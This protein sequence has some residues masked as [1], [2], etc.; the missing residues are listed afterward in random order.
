H[1]KYRLASISKTFASAL[2]GHLVDQGQLSYDTPVNQILRPQDFPVKRWRSP[3]EKS[4]H[5]VNITVRQLL[6]HTAGLHITKTSDFDNVTVTHNTTSMI[7]KFKDEPLHF[8]P[9]TR[10]KYSN[11]GFQVL[12]AVIE[13]VTKRTFVAMMRDFLHQHNL[14]ETK[15]ETADLI[16]D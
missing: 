13:A 9:G 8:K 10:F 1:S 14:T 2:I 6:S 12:G 11:Y 4:D 5:S 16:T 15:V 3:G 7:H